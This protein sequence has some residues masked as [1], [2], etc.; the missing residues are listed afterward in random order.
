M[1][2]YNTQYTMKPKYNC[3]HKKNI[4]RPVLSIAI[5]L[6][7]L[8]IGTH[9]S[10]QTYEIDNV[11]NQ[12]ITTCSGTF[13][14]SG[15]PSYNYR[16]REDYKV[17]FTAGNGGHIIVSFA[18]FSL[19]N[20]GCDDYL[21]IYN[22]SSTSSSLI[23][24]YCGSNSPGTITSS[25]SSL[26]F[27]FHSNIA[28][29]SGGWK[30]SIT[31]S[32]ASPANAGND[33]ALQICA[34]ATVTENDLFGALTGADA[35]GTWSPAPAGIGIYTYTVSSAYCPDDQSQVV[36]SEKPMTLDAGI[37]GYLSICNGESFTEGDL[38]N[39]LSGTPDVG[40]TWSP[41]PPTGGGTY[42]YTVTDDCGFSVSSN[43]IV[44]EE[45]GVGLTGDV[46]D[47][48]ICSGDVVNRGY[49]VSS[50]STTVFWKN[51]L[52]EFGVDS[53]SKQ[54]INLTT[55]PTTVTYTVTATSL[56]GCQKVETFDVTINPEPQISASE[57]LIEICSGEKAS[58]NFSSTLPN[59]TFN[60]TADDGTSGTGDINE[61]KTNTGTTPVEILY[62]ISGSVSNGCS[63]EPIT[64][65]V[66]VY[67]V[68]EVTL[69]DPGDVCLN[70]DDL[71]FNAT[72]VPSGNNTGVFTTTAPAGLTDN[73]NGTATLDVSA[74]G[75]GTFEVTYT[76]TDIDGNACV[77]SE[78]VSFEIFD[79]PVV[80]VS[81]VKNVLC[82]GESTGSAVFT[83][84]GGTSPYNL[85]G[86]IVAMDVTSPYTA[87]G[88]SAGTYQVTVTDANNCSATASV[89]ITEPATALE[90][91]VTSGT[92]SC[93][94]GTT[95][96]TVTASGGTSPYKYSLDN[97][98]YQES[99]EFTVSSGSYV[100]YV[101]DE[102][103]CMFTVPYTVPYACLA[104]IKTASV[105]GDGEVGDVITYSFT[106]S[107]E[108]NVPLT[109]V[110]VTDPLVGISISGGPID[111]A[112]GASDNSTFTASYT[113]T[114]D[115]I[116]AGGVSHGNRHERRSSDRLIG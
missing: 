60:W 11:N 73:G 16:D 99:N 6:W 88:L 42:T 35:G 31:C 104:L 85:S 29:T 38:F 103:G 92:L 83:I 59:T 98:T 91:S 19:F 52:G 56:S 26:T 23:G 3:F 66:I 95:S 71:Q 90:A 22:G 100:V 93:N 62:T 36:V 61:V 70:G 69:S 76:Y 108:G 64:A 50:A 14:D 32:C 78:T 17:T 21:K 53:I 107:N 55:A 15:G 113:I 40:G 27:V 13:Y 30:A 58:L 94:A 82:K 54:F 74:A 45:P 33:G 41:T 110:T 63:S 8:L 10:A 106:V 97:I 9:V 81:S 68:P 67:P 109:N 20:W 48:I 101:K 46:S 65:K 39:A 28:A 18:S 79:S 51:T 1:K 77:N 105:G 102:N 72:P 24:T 57:C 25:G 80:S 115:D 112:V 86:D 47:T 34:G 96:L 75:A 49:K 5:L 7:T 2:S 84:T 89:T 44:V 12:T 116:N 37:N 114:Q 4:V 87:T 111:L 43:V